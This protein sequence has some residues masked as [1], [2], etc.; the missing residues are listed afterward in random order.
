M[1]ASLK[2]PPDLEKYLLPADGFCDQ[3]ASDNEDAPLDQSAKERIE[4]LVREFNEDGTHTL[5]HRAE[6]VDNGRKYLIP[7]QDAK[8]LPLRARLILDRYAVVDAL[9]LYYRNRTRTTFIRLLVA[10]FLAMLLFEVF[11]HCWVEIFPAGAWPRLLFW[12][13][14]LTWVGALLLWYHAHK[15]KYQKKYHDYRALAEG[16]RVQF[17]WNLLALPDR[18][19][20]YYLTKQQGELE[21]IRRALGWWH[22]RDEKTVADSVLSADQLQAQKSLVRRL[23]VQGQFE[24]YAKVAGP[25]EERKGKRCKRWGEIF[26]LTS[27]VLSFGVGVC[28]I[29]NVI[30]PPAQLEHAAEHQS[31]LKPLEQGLVIAISMLLVGAAVM[32][33]YG[34]KMAF[35]EHTRQY[36]GT[37][38]LFQRADTQLTDGPLTEDEKKVFRTLGTEALQE[39]ADWLLLHRDRPLE[40][41]VP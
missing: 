38:R 8:G 34:E 29:V 7:E 22:T 14:P 3:T 35:A 40:V 39:N 32:V 6:A 18:V 11:A 21:W 37:S 41:V 10:A 26:F 20:K 1:I 24:Y 4:K 2:N 15:R 12:L 30:R 33:A 13:Y 27:L 16:L 31:E 36:G 9:A 17:F 23:W 19:E 25:R 28:E 5:V